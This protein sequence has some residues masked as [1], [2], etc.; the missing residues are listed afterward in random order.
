[1][2]VSKAVLNVLRSK[3]TAAAEKQV[4]NHIASSFVETTSEKSAKHATTAIKLD[5]L[6]ALLTKATAAMEKQELCL[7]VSSSTSN[8]VTKL[9]RLIN[10]VTMAIR[11]AASIALLVKVF[12]ALEG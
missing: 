5:A 11:L 6:I 12:N 2:G 9:L 8:V 7:T 4:N 3:A 10:N 1:M